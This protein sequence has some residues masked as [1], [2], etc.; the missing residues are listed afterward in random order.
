VGIGRPEVGEVADWVLSDIRGSE[1]AELPDRIDHACR[2][3]T[4]ILVD[5]IEA[6]ML[7]FN[8]PPPT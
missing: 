4:A 2:A 6:A 3:V 7:R 5:G 8:T 1:A